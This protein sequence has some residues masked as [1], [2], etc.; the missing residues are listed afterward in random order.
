MKERT[1]IIF[2]PQGSSA[3]LWKEELVGWYSWP[4]QE[5][6]MYQEMETAVTEIQQT[7]FATFC[8]HPWHLYINFLIYKKKKN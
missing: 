8:S 3:V 4:A 2:I 7:S 6:A 5:K 1:C